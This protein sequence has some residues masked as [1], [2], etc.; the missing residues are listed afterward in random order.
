MNTEEEEETLSEWCVVSVIWKHLL[1]SR[2]VLN[3]GSTSS[4]QG[5]GCGK[6]NKTSSLCLTLNYVISCSIAKI[7]LFKHR[8]WSASIFLCVQHSQFEHY[9]KTEIDFFFNMNMQFSF[10]AMTTTSTKFSGMLHHEGICSDT[11][12]WS[13]QLRNHGREQN[14]VGGKKSHKLLG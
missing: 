8:W 10:T 4:L 14:L 11:G 9:P 2:S 13:H 1:S 12:V 7:C 5:P 6:R 3:P